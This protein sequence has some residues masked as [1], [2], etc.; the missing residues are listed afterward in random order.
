MAGSLLLVGITLLLVGSLVLA[1]HASD[2]GRN[3]LVLVLP[4]TG[5]DHVRDHWRD[6]RLALLLRVLGTALVVGACG[7]RI[8]EDPLLLSNPE[9]LFR[10]PDPA[11][12]GSTMHQIN[13]FALSEDGI[14]AYLRN[15]DDPHLTGQ[16]RGQRFAY[17]RAE[18]INGVFA[19]RQGTGFL[20]ELEVRLLL[21]LDGDALRERA[22][23]YVRPE[24]PDAP[25]LHVSW[26][27]ADG[28]PETR[29][30]RGGYRLELQLAPLLPGQLRG[31]MQL[32]LPGAER[33]FVAGNFVAYTNHLQYR[34]DGRVDL[35]YNHPDTLEYLARQYIEN[36][37]PP[38]ALARIEYHD[39]RMRPSRNTG[40]TTARI[41]LRNG[42]LEERRLRFERMD[43]GWSLQPG[44]VEVRVLQEGDRLPEDAGM[45]AA[46][47]PPLKMTFDELATLAGQ[48]VTVRQRDGETR[49]VQVLEL[50]RGKLR[51]ETRVGSG[52]V[53][54]TLG[55]EDI[56][57]LRL[58][59]GR[60]VQLVEDAPEAA[61]ADDASSGADAPPASA[62][63]PASRAD[64][65]R[66]DTV[67]AFAALDGRRVELV[68]GNGRRRSG[69]LHVGRDEL[70]LTVRLGAGSM[71][72][73]YSPEEVD[74]VRAL[75]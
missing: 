31:F 60:P 14:L 39:T 32:I 17:D 22:T 21:G 6:L 1:R 53:Q 12:A 63:A 9:R 5:L 24:D 72:Y 20:P 51:V 29:V 13:R 45:A 42:R 8:A 57:A 47:M 59:T 28:R 36:Q 4:F 75:D 15:D 40:A 10:R 11:V 49:Q 23:V 25:E 16:V 64:L 71:E 54:Y 37:Y 46:G 58:A 19:A 61:V 43:L 38:E 35:T 7:I 48:T 44:G 70:R 65:V 30:Y 67:Q 66:G 62:P 18:L 56:V 33:T 69:I 74:G 50:R 34:E 73:F 68:D 26:L 3:W 27:D 52:Q 2:H 55:P 41:L